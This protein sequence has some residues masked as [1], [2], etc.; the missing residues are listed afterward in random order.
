MAGAMSTL[1]EFTVDMRG[2]INELLR[3]AATR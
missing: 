2:P 3:Q 1:R